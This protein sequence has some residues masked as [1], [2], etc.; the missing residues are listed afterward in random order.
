M[1]TIADFKTKALASMQTTVDS[2]GQEITKSRTYLDRV[3]NQ[4]GAQAV[5]AAGEVRL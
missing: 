4:E 5:L 1:D 3:R 2:L